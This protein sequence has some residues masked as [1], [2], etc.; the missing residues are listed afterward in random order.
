MKRYFALALMVAVVFALPAAAQKA[1]DAVAVDPAVH[2]VILENEH[3]RVFDAR[4]SRA[5]KSPMHSHPPFVFIGLDHA[6]VRLTQRDGQRVL[7]DIYPGQVMWMGETIEHSWELL[8]GNI[9]VIAVEIKS[10]LKG[11]PPPAVK[12][13][14][15][16]SVAVS[17]DVHRVI[18]ENEHVRIFDGRATAGD[19]SPM[20]SHPPTLLVMLGHGRGRLTLPDGK[21]VAV[22]YTP[23]QVMWTGEGMQHS[24]VMLAGDPRVIA[25]EPK[26]AHTPA[27]PAA[28]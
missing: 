10:A 7:L 26:S 5:A 13:R 17:P 3:V 23:G 19:R 14:A 20:H 16:D 27:K 6:R 24:W 15:D 25:I 1:P 11:T 9:H 8:S 12:Y 21:T 18:A 22:D 28:D 2:N 4:A